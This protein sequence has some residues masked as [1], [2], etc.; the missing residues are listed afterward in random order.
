[1]RRS[2]VDAFGAV[3]VSFLADSDRKQVSQ[4][5]RKEKNMAR[6]SLLFGVRGWFAILLI[7]CLSLTAIRAQAQQPQSLARK[8]NTDGIWYWTLPD[9]PNGL[10]PVQSWSG[11]GSTPNGEIYVGGMDHVQNSALYRLRSGILHHVGDARSASEAVN[12]WKPGE[13]AEKFHTHPTWLA[14]RMYVATLSS[15]SL[16]ESYLSKR[17]FHWYAFD[18]DTGQFLDLSVREP[19]GVG[20]EHGGLVTIAADAPR[21]WIYGAL[22]PTGEIYRYNVRSGRTRVIG[23]PE[24]ER[25]YVYPGRFMWVDSRGRLYL[26]AG[27]DEQAYYGAPYD[28]EIFNH[29]RYYD[30]GR[31]FGEM[32]D[33]SLHHQR[34]IDAGQC[35][36]KD[37][38]CYLSDNTGHVY[39]FEEAGPTWRY[40]GDIGQTSPKQLGNTWVFHVSKDQK[41]AYIITARGDFYDFDLQTGAARFVADLRKLEPELADKQLYGHD[42]W[43]KEGRFYFAA[44]RETSPNVV[45]VGIDPERLMAAVS[46]R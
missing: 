37:G 10:K 9:T 20:A 11:A 17:G 24:Y 45:L 23:R 42:A 7:L 19:G 14:G 29:V 33:W 13:V 1:M 18:K 4:K 44:F 25:P 8:G 5:A 21:G 22:N 39:K 30:P 26:T 36:R 31:G 40:L 27:N 34:A 16:D 12:N 46:D 28:P 32:K 3:L 38:V 6:D 35:F 15:S 43:D 2:G 41:R